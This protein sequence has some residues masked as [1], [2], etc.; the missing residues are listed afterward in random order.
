MAVLKKSDPGIILIL[1]LEL[2]RNLSARA[3]AIQIHFNESYVG[4]FIKKTQHIFNNFIVLM[5]Q[6]R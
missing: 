4:N 1:G 3:R 5:S 2:S 6:S